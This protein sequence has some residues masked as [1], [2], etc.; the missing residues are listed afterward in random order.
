[1]Q[2]RYFQSDNWIIRLI[3]Q[4]R[5]CGV[6]IK[7]YKR[8]IPVHVICGVFGVIRVLKSDKSKAPRAASVVHRHEYVFYPSVS[9]KLVF[10]VVLVGLYACK[11]VTR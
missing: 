3:G 4:V 8:A 11:R 5:I 7:G 6:V 9:F 1:M 10:Q 2:K